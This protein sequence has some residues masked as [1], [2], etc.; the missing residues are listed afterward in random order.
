MVRPARGTVLWDFDG[1]LAWREGL[2]SGC[3]ADAVY[4][5]AA[6]LRG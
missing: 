1:T 6:Y 4:G 2:W 3:V 5:V